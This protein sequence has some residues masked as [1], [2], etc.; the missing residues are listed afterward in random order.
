MSYSVV[1]STVRIYLLFSYNKTG[2]VKCHFHY[3]ISRVYSTNMIGDCWFGLDLGAQ[4]VTVRCLLHCT[5]TPLTPPP[6]SQYHSDRFWG[7]GF[8]LPL[9]KG[10]VP[11]WISWNSSAWG[12]L[13][14][15]PLLLIYLYHYGIIDIYFILWVKI[16]RYFIYYFL[17]SFQVWLLRILQ[18]APMILWY[19]FSI[20]F[21]LF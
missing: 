4:A 2:E 15:L 16:W 5:V 19:I 8:L 20:N 17:K 3:I 1:C 18:L 10:E 11:V 9:L 7:M 12:G 21:L 14:L 6:C 13:S